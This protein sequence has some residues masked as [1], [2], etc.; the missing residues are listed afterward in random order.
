MRRP[1]TL[2]ASLFK[3]RRLPSQLPESTRTLVSRLE[4]A[5]KKRSEFSSELKK[6]D[7]EIREL[8][9]QLPMELQR[10]D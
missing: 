8:R 1:A 2:L 4:E 3:L 9:R 5:L 6:L 10:R 7:D